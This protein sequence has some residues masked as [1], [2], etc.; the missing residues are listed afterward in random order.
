MPPAADPEASPVLLPGFEYRQ[1]D[2]DGVTI[3]CDPP[4]TSSPTRCVASAR[5]LGSAPEV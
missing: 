5:F 2:A 4:A 1:I 3:S